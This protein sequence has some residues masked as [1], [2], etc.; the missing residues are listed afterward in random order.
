[1]PAISAICPEKQMEKGQAAL[2]TYLISNSEAGK[3]PAPE[4]A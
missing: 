2:K 1:M 3:G 4:L